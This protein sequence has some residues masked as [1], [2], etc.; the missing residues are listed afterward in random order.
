MLR[1]KGLRFHRLLL[2]TH[3]T[4]RGRLGLLQELKATSFC[5]A[6]E[7]VR[8]FVFDNPFLLA[9][10]QVRYGA[11]AQRSGSDVRVY[12]HCV[13]QLRAEN[14]AEDKEGHSPKP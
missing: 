9:E 10:A 14:I 6:Q 5:G 2:D 1:L 3:R 7:I 11:V 12:S 4:R 13:L 8:D